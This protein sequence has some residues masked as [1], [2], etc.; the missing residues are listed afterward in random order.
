MTDDDA[1]ELARLAEAATPGPWVPQ[2]PG[3][4]VLS[5]TPGDGVAHPPVAVAWS[6]EIAAYIAAA[7]PAAV[8][9]L[10]AERKRMRAALED[11]V[12]KAT[13][14]HRV[15]TDAVRDV[16][17][18]FPIGCRVRRSKEGISKFNL[19]HR[20]SFTGRVVGYSYGGQ[21]IRV[22]GDGK[23]SAQ[24]FGACFWER[25]E[26]ESKSLSA[27]LAPEPPQ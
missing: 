18:R 17:E 11:L 9:D 26:A 23:R 3:R 13:E 27:A 10:L 15:E 7:N 4:A 22:I 24:V 12:E 2:L 25:I 5:T 14:R 8:L 21:A 16:K 20:S 1:A 19:S 6:A